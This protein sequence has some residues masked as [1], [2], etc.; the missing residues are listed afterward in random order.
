MT[1]LIHM[2]DFFLFVA[3]IIVIASFVSLYRAIEGP[4]IF[5][6]IIAVNVIGTKTIVLLVLIGFIYER[7]DFFDIALVYAILNFIMT[8]AATRY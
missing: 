2:P 6:R 3:V 5:N 7:P 1:G 4:G 8:I